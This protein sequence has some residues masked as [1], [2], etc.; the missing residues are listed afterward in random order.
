MP[1]PPLRIFTA[2]AAAAVASADVSAVSGRPSDV[3][4]DDAAGDGIHEFVWAPKN[5]RRAEA[6]AHFRWNTRFPA[7]ALAF[8][9][10]A[11]HDAA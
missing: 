2:L 6:Q 10:Q 5:P 11:G 8:E 4:R 1:R 7:A 3:P 9:P